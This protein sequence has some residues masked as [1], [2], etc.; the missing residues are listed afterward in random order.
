MI[1]A[2][3]SFITLIPQLKAWFDDLVAAYVALKLASMKQENRDALKKALTEYDQRDLEKAIG[4]PN[5]GEAS[6]DAGAT[7]IDHVPPGMP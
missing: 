1:S 5:P 2:I 3:I 7:I 6:G 4:S